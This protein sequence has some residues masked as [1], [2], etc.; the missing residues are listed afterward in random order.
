MTLDD[1]QQKLTE[2]IDATARAH[3]AA[4]AYEKEHGRGESTH[5]AHT[6]IHEALEALERAGRLLGFE[7]ENEAPTRR[8]EDE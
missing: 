6:G 1:W 4:H 3:A 8:E 2:A 7:R 5:R